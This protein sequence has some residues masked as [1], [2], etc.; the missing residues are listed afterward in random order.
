MCRG[1][2]LLQK[3][4]LSDK[5]GFRGRCILDRNKLEACASQERQEGE[6]RETL[7]GYY[8]GQT[9]RGGDTGCACGC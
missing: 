6:E 5:R 9:D 7:A 4:T 2:L 1:G 8:R 3:L